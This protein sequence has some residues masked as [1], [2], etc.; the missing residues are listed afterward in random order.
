MTESKLNPLKLLIATA[1]LL[2]MGPLLASPTTLAVNIGGLAY[3]GSDGVHYQADTLKS[4]AL[5]GQSKTIKGSQDSELYR[6]FRMGDLALELP[7]ENGLYE[8]TYKFA[9]PFETPVGQRVFDV[10]AQEQVVIK[11]LDVRLARD[12][13]I[14]SSLDRTVTGIEVKNGV[15]KLGFK[16]IKGEPL[17]H[18]LIVR[19]QQPMAPHWKLVWQ[20]EFNVPGQPDA[21][22]WN[23]DI[24]PARKVNNEDQAYTKRLKNARVEQGKLIIEA[25]QEEMEGKSYSSA[26]LVTRGKASWQYG[27]I[28]VRAKLPSGKGTWPAIWMLPTDRRHGAWPH[29]GEIDIMEHVGYNP[30]TIYGTVHTGAFN[31]IQ[32][33]QRGDSLVV[34]DAEE[35]Y[36]LYSIIWD[37]KGIAF[38]VDQ[39]QYH[40]FKNEQTDAQAWPFDQPFYLILNLAVGGNWGGKH[41][42]APDIWPRPMEID[43]VRIYH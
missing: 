6:S 11:D 34:A 7:M 1:L 13:K 28:E 32:G 27:K 5:L 18:A 8:I 37:E 38:F 26:R 43:Y 14:L 29:S 4:S 2:V 15:L 9:E 3:T 12:G 19:K 33:T 20:D 30:S 24:W 16:A 40:Y 41:G 23:F 21:S 42:V 25:H 36:H 31:H 35:S 17:L 22:K 39:T 10:L